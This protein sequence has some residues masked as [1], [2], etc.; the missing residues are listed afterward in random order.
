MDAIRDIR[1]SALL[2]ACCMAVLLGGLGEAHAAS[3]GPFRDVF[4]LDFQ[5]EEPRNCTAADVDLD[6]ERAAAFFRRARRVSYRT[7]HDAYETFPCRALGVMRLHGQHCTW[8]IN[9]G[10]YATVRCGG[11]E[12]HYAC[13]ECQDLLTPAR[14][15]VR[16]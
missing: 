10:L 5:S 2:V 7:I 8:S 1:P 9:A 3:S 13:D 15:P 6:N 12:V 16:P 4:V 11:K 14:P